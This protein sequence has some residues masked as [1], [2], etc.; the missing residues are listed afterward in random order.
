M[1]LNDLIKL[2]NEQADEFNQW[3]ALGADE[4]VMFALRQVELAKPGQEPIGYVAKYVKR[5]LAT[6]KAVDAVIFVEKND[7]ATEAIYTSP[8]QYE[9]LSV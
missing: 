3:D 1:N 4:Q 5:D 2:W 6:H 7:H 9:P 8:P